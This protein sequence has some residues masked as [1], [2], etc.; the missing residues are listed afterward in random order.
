MVGCKHIHPSDMYTI[1]FTHTRNSTHPLTENT[2]QFSVTAIL[3]KS[4]VFDSARRN[5]Y[6]LNPCSRSHCCF[7]LSDFFHVFMSS[8]PFK[9]DEIN[10]IN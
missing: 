8:L 3:P 9:F 2:G 7:L 5:S 6:Y 4:V 1:L 10:T